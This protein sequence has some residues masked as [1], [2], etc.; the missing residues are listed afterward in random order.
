MSDCLQQ[1]RLASIYPCIETGCAAPL[2][3]KRSSGDSL[4]DGAAYWDT[5]R[6]REY[7]VSEPCECEVPVIGMPNTPNRW[8]CRTCAGKVQKPTNDKRKRP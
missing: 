4:P 3:R 6:K 8:T 1:R 5:V 2:L 7:L